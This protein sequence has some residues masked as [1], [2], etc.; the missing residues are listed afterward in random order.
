MSDFSRI[1]TCKLNKH[2]YYKQFKLNNV[3]L[4]HAHLIYQ[5]LAE[6]E[7]KYQNEPRGPSCYCTM[8]HGCYHKHF[9]VKP[10]IV[11]DAGLTPGKDKGVHDS[12]YYIEVTVI[13]NAL[14]ETT[15]LKKVCCIYWLMFSSLLLSI[16]LWQLNVVTPICTW[17]VSNQANNQQFYTFLLSDLFLVFRVT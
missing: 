11:K 6:C 10:K 1:F 15:F 4:M 9:Y 16:Y 12:D 17:T 3:G 13:N 8:F 2:Y 5:N 7:E 14:L